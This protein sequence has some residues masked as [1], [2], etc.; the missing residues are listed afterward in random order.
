MGTLEYKDNFGMDSDGPDSLSSELGYG[1]LDNT[2]FDL[3]AIP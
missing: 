2:N 3:S 1:G